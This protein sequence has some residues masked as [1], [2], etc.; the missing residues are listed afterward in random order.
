MINTVPKGVKLTGIIEPAAFKLGQ[1]A[2]TV[3]TDKLQYNVTFRVRFHP[4]ASNAPS[5]TYH[6]AGPATLKRDHRHYV[7]EGKAWWPRSQM[8]SDNLFCGA[9]L[10]DTRVPIPSAL[11]PLQAWS[12]CDVL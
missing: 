6:H 3:A 5:G 8:H 7:L 9:S 4:A 1:F 11:L 10:V 2:P 12:I